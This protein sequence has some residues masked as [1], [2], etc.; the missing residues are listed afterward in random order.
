[1]EPLHHENLT[2]PKQP[3]C[4]FGICKAATFWT[5]VIFENSLKI[6]WAFRWVQF[7]SIFK[8]HE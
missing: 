2:W 6:T 7:E 4:Q 5:R 1:M 8:Q 3:F